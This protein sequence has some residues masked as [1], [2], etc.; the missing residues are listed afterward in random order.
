M[1]HSIKWLVMLLLI[2]V[3]GSSC[4]GPKQSSAEPATTSTRDASTQDTFKPSTP[5]TQLHDTH[6]PPSL[7]DVTEPRPPDA[8]REPTRPDTKGPKEFIIPD[9]PSP[10]VLYDVSTPKGPDTVAQET[11]PEGC[12]ANETWCSG[13]CIDT[14][15]DDKH[16]GMCNNLCPSGKAC[17]SG[18]CLT[19]SKLW[20]KRG[21][22]F[23]PTGRLMDWSYAGYQHGEKAIPSTKPT[24]LLTSFG[25]IADDGKDDTAAFEKALA[26]V[27]TKGGTIGIPKGTFILQK[28][29]RLPSRVVLQGAGVRDTII[30]I[31]KSLTQ[32]Y[33]NTGL[34][35]GGHSSYAFGRGFF[36]IIGANPLQSQYGLTTITSEAKRAERKIEVADTTKL[37]VGQWM[38]M[39]QREDS[40]RTLANHLYGDV[41]K[42][43]TGSTGVR[44]EFPNRVTSIKGKVVTFERPFTIDIKSKWKPQ[45]YSLASM[46][47]EVGIEHLTIAFPRSRYPGHFQEKGYNAI[48][49]K[50]AY[51]CWVYQVRIENAD[52]AIQLGSS[53]N[54]TVDGVTIVSNRT[55]SMAGHQGL[56]SAH[57]ADNL[58][59][60]FDIQGRFHHD[61]TVDWYT[62]GNVFTKGKG[63]NL[64][65]DHHRSG[66]HHNLWTELDLGQGTA[67]FISGGATSRGPHTGAYTTFWNITAS[68]SL[69]LPEKNYGPLINLV[70]F[71]TKVT[72][73]PSPH[74]WWLEII[75][76]SQLGPPNLWEA[77]RQRRLGHR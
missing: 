39:V 47:T 56:K 14:K 2:V 29:L 58:F 13:L 64:R 26:A 49:T 36:E 68:R 11:S 51:N 20:G 60:R 3:W 28:N 44:W 66:P 40:K 43:G 75:N 46:H 8:P 32:L 22:A 10:D 19:P 27:A 48:D 1:S 61:L 12:L 7:P 17:F 52:T 67:P 76:P 74:N 45:L 69:P 38:L 5:D 15:N 42:G 34:D 72:K 65:M 54:V 23:K 33:G 31:P 73:S 6:E 25:A 53:Y 37:K 30:S 50:R 70:G 77:M 18:G 9:V 57:G 16:C 55:S 21:E 41:M 71:L 24:L 63:R 59:V 4:G 35:S 62:L